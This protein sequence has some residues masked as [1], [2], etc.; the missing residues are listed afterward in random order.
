MERHGGAIGDSSSKQNLYVKESSPSSGPAASESEQKQVVLD[1]VLD[2]D[3]DGDDPNDTMTIGDTSDYKNKQPMRYDTDW[4]NQ[5]KDVLSTDAAASG[6]N[7][8]SSQNYDAKLDISYVDGDDK[9]DFYDSDYVADMI[10]SLASKLNDMNL[11]TGV[12]LTLP[13]LK[14]AASEELGKN[15]KSGTVEDEIDMKYKSFK[16]FDIVQG[17]SDHYFGFANVNI[18]NSKE[19]VRRIQYE[20]EALQKNLPE[21]IYVRVYENRMDI[22]RAVIIGPAGTPYHDGLFFFDAYFPP[23]YPY[24]PPVLNFHSGGLRINPNLYECGK[25]CLSLLNTW[26]GRECEMWRPSNSTMLQVLVSI[27]ALILTEKPFFNEPGNEGIENTVYGKLNSLAYNEDV[28]LLSCRIMLYSLRKPPMHFGDFVAG[29]FRYRG[30]A[31]LLACKTYMSGIPVGLD[32]VIKEP[33]RL[34]PEAFKNSLKALFDV[35]LMEFT[36]KGAHCDGIQ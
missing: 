10:E 7:S 8:G 32:H 27:Q 13:S 19:W 28:F 1:N 36:G 12:E 23:N 25:V 30:R 11:S 18:N 31:F 21:M 14:N 24:V 2:L 6:A 16:Q 29:H 17:H 5:V 20:W 35:L 33:P 4:Q 22:M 3:D 34:F 26:P 15:K 9:D